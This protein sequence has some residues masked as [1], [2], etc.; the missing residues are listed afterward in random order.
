MMGFTTWMWATIAGIFGFGILLALPGSIKTALAR[1]LGIDENQAGGV[2]AWLNLSLI[3]MML[4]GGMLVDSWGAREVLILGSALSAVGVFSISLSTSVRHALCAVLL[5]GVGAGCVGT[6]A[7]VLMP[8]TF[9]ENSPAASLNLGYV[10]FG[11]G[12]LLTPVVV[13]MMLQVTTLR[14]T[15]G[16]V[17][18]CLLLPALLTVIAP[19]DLAV[20]PEGHGSVWSTPVVWLAAVLFMLYGPL[21]AWLGTSAT[22]Y[23]A[24]LG[25]SA[26]R[27][28]VLMGAVWLVFLGAR[29]CVALLQQRELLAPHSDSWLIWMVALLAAV[30]LGNLAGTHSKGNAA[31]A[32]LLMGSFLGP[33]FPTL[34][35]FVLK[36]VDAAQQGTAF[37]AMYAIGTA[38]GLA[39]APLFAPTRPVAL[40]VPLYLLIGVALALVGTGLAL[41]LTQ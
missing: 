24:D 8:R 5:T 29:L 37:G 33:L 36:S 25:Y 28:M 11:L 17:S 14:R 20:T 38:G 39:M 6:S 23:L 34:A 4:I 19:D 26:R 9:F 2:L 27:S 7:T 21:E 18:I 30:A 31:V 40:R 10:F 22:R 13:N 3:P 32:L 16:V 1:R 35:G 41:A 12:A 15:L